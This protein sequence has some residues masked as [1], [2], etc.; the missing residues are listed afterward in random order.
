ME[1]TNQ[2]E[3]LE[4]LDCGVIGLGPA[5][6]SAS[7]ELTKNGY[8][9][10]AFE[11]G[12]VGGQVNMTASIENYPGYSG[13]AIDLVD[14]FNEDVER[15]KK[16][17]R[18]KVVTSMVKS[19][20]RDGDLFKVSTS[21]ATFLFRS[22]IVCSGTRYRPYAIPD[23]DRTV[24]GRGFSRCAICDG[25]L[26][27]GKDVMVVGGGEAA[28]QEALYL[29]SICHS[30]TLINRRTIFRASIRDVEAFKACPN[31]RIIA[32]AVTV[33]CSGNGHLEHVVI[34]D[35]NDETDASLQTLDVE[36]C[37]IYIGSDAATGFVKIPEALDE[38]GNM[39]VD[40]DME[41]VGVPGLFGAGDV[42]DTPLR[43]VSTAV[44]FG[45]LAG[46]A[47]T[48]YLESRR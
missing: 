35:P 45:S 30:V 12:N 8:S 37:F 13:P 10:T 31:T 40:E 9:V 11:Y 42:I 28:F 1:N 7:L 23:P 32:P 25:P 20:E 17:G 36:A 44:G 2:T 16:E 34:K 5:G 43:Q 39:K 48:R 47:C 26:Y 27:K 29:A 14:R 3:N 18:L 41:V 6:V 19:L 24:R 15:M 38:K 33:S 46:I 21:R 22:V 4:I